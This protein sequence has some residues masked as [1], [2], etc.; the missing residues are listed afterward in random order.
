MSEMTRH[1]NN[2]MPQIDF[3]FPVEGDCREKHSI[4]SKECESQK[5]AHKVYHILFIIRN[6]AVRSHNT[7]IDEK[8][9]LSG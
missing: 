8:F 9:K 3:H 2:S 4:G 7:L 1:E 6:F 5:R